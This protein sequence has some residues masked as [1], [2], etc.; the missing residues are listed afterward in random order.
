M[1]FP[2]IIVYFAGDLPFMRAGFNEIRENTRRGSDKQK[3]NHAVNFF[4][5]CQG[6]T[7]NFIKLL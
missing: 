4:G 1:C 6:H 5:I 2:I 7:E 3:A